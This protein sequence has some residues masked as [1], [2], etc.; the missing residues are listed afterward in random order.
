MT[1]ALGPA[2]LDLLDALAAQAPSPS[3]TPS[4]TTFSPA[5]SS[6]G[7]SKLLV[8]KWLTDRC[9]AFRIKDQ[10][11]GKGRTVYVLNSCPF[12]P[13]HGDPDACI[14]QEPGGKLSAKCFHNSCQGNNW[15][16][17]KEKIGAPNADH[18]DPPL[19][20]QSRRS[21]VRSK[22]SQHERAAESGPK[23]ATIGNGQEAQSVQEFP[24]IQ[25]N[26]RQL[27]DVAAD[28]LAAIIANN[29]PPT[30]FQRCRLLTRLR[31]REGEQPPILE[32]MAEA[33]IRG[34]LARVANWTSVK[35]FTT[36]ECAP[37]MD[38]VKDLA[39]LPSWDGIP[40]IQAVVECPVFAKNGLL[41]S[42]QGFHPDAGIWYEPS[43]DLEVPQVSVAPSP[44]EISR[45]RDLLLIDLLGDFPFKDDASRAHALC[46]LLLPFVRPMI[47]GCTPLHLLDAPTE[48][49]GKTLLATATAFPA[50]GAEVPSMAEG[51][52]TDEWH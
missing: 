2:P 8:D 50:L 23:L 21:P 9:V 4:T 44:D 27:R 45:A 26:S 52:S 19:R 40:S 35:G 46:A 39:N 33:A 34:H 15:Q 6:N 3:T 29:D 30:I 1:N 36:T 43:P 32:P 25:G 51:D 41:I 14:M 17:F 20:G 10:P 18:Y 37:Q 47:A 7:R 13:S 31:M 5:T 49:T 38:V 12:D 48:G 28:G 11:D 16:M 22:S 24:E 42:S